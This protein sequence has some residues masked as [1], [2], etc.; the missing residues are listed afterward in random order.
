MEPQFV[1]SAGCSLAWGWNGPFGHVAEAVL[2][3]ALLAAL[4]LAAV[5]PSLTVHPALPG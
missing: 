3:D 5:L 1:F 4:S 2:G